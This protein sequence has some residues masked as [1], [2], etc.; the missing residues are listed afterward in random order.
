MNTSDHDIGGSTNNCVAEPDKAQPGDAMSVGGEDGVV[1]GGEGLLGAD[2][3]VAES[4]G[5]EKAS[6]G[7]E[8]D[9]SQGGQVGQHFPDLEVAGVVDGGLGAQRAAFFVVL[10]CLIVVCL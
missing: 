8:A 6:V 1:D 9:L 5:A 4:L 7:G 3:V 2:R 10:Y